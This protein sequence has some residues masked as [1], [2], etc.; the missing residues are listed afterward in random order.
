L[1]RS[2]PAH[3]ASLPWYSRP[4]VDLALS[5]E[6]REL[7]ASFA[8]LLSKASS[9]DLVR[10]AEPAG[11][12]PALW[13]TLLETGALSMA[14]PEELGGWGASLLDLALVAEEVGRALAPAPVVETQVA[15][16]LLA[17][18]APGRAE[19]T[20]SAALR[21][22]QL[23]TMAVHPAR[24]GVAGLVPAGAICDALIVPVDDRLLL[25][26]PSATARRTVANLGSA[27]LAD[28]DVDDG[29]ELAAG[30]AAGDLFETSV[31]EW[32]V[33]TAAALVGMATTAHRAACSYAAERRAFGAVIGSYQGVAHP[34]A[35]DATALDGA[36]LLWRRAAW[37]LDAGQGRGRELASMAFA[38][39]SEAAERATYDA[40]HFH[41]GYG[42]MLE[43]DVQLFY[44]RARGWA[45]VWGDAEAGYR[46]AATA[47]YGTAAKAKAAVR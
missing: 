8:N 20:L 16:R 35:D 22:D 41:G 19:E 34:L 40:I 14:V 13:R 6:Q 45:R 37:S 2:V 12:D 28:V 44:R 30:G 24:A 39:A 25:V 1:H 17:A 26:S 3:T 36:R 46:R 7:V 43:H 27:P 18:A 47:R 32:L 15:A 5:D 29:L 38:F 11:F 33:L 10:A 23:V 31:D 9:P 4:F 42:F 21:G